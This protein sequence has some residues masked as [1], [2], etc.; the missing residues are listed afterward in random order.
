MI[1]S[2]I[3][4]VLKQLHH[5]LYLPSR[6]VIMHHLKRSLPLMPS[7]LFTW[8]ITYGDR[9]MLSYMTNLS[10]VGIYSVADAFGLLFYLLITYPWLGAYQPAVMQRYAHA[11]DNYATLHTI[12]SHNQRIMWYALL[13][14]FAVLCIGFVIC[15]PLI[16]IIIPVSYHMAIP[17][18]FAIVTSQILLLG[19]NFALCFIQFSKRTTFLAFAWCIPA[20]L[21]ITLNLM[22]IPQWNLYGCV[23]ATLVAYATYFAIALGYNRFLVQHL[24]P[25]ASH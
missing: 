24:H 21:K 3:G 10:A 5:T 9:I 20:L 22:L 13:L 14:L 8:L 23:T 7:L 18:I 25:T 1:C 15:M 6:Q 4:Y 16:T 11:K 2:C 19:T 17:L 12:E